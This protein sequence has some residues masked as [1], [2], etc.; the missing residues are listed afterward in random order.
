LSF[1]PAEKAHMMNFG[2]PALWDKTK[3]VV[4]KELR[5]NTSP[6]RASLSLGIGVLV[7]LSPLYGLHTIIILALAFIFRLN[8]PLALIA[9]GITLLPFVPF[10]IAGG[11]F[12]GKLIVPVETAS[13]I[14][15][16]VTNLMTFERF[17]NM[18][19][20]FAKYCKRFIPADVFSTV[21][22]EAG[23]GVVDGFV[24][25]LIGCSVFAVAGAVITF[26][27]C[28]FFLLRRAK[29]RGKGTMS[30]IR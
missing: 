12:M 21:E 23:H 24:Q 17:W 29:T 18:A 10:W 26:V 3:R 5:A 7:G 20:D 27:V 1:L 4:A 16:Y 22:E 2:V 8:R 13:R 15:D 30:E 25:W 28:Y 19:A 6:F 14:I 11:I 9:S